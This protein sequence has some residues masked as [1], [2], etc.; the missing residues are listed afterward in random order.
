MQRYMCSASDRTITVIVT[1]D[2]N[3][4]GSFNQNRFILYTKAL[5]FHDLRDDD[6]LTRKNIHI[7]FSIG[8]QRT[9]RRG[10]VVMFI[11]A[12]LSDVT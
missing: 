8:L 12:P 5:K 11:L 3:I 1:N 6:S 9:S 10:E 4:T 7:L 2:E